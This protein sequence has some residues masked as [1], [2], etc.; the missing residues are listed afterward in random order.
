MKSISY[1]VVFYLQTFVSA[2]TL[3]VT[4]PTVNQTFIG[5]HI[6]FNFTILRNGMLF[7]D[8]ATTIVTNSSDAVIFKRF[9]GTTNKAHVSFQMHA[10]PGNYTFKVIA[11]GSYNNVNDNNRLYMDI[12]QDIPFHVV[13]RLQKK[14]CLNKNNTNNTEKV[15]LSSTQSHTRQ[16]TFLMFVLTPIIV[17]AL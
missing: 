1:Y 13:P 15:S 17:M 3:F 2:D 4:S 5:S 10:P 6:S 8:N 7:L 9:S 11:H 14:T 16:H 12:K